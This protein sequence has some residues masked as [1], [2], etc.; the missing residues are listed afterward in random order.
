MAPKQRWIMGR[1]TKRVRLDG[2]TLHPHYYYIDLLFAYTKLQSRSKTTTKEIPLNVASLEGELSFGV[3]LTARPIFSFGVLVGGGSVAIMDA[4]FKLDLPK[5]FA[6]FTA[7]K[8]TSS[9]PL[10]ILPS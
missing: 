7:V 1:P 10:L 5:V 3:N 2:D 8:S 6:K 4:G 9:T